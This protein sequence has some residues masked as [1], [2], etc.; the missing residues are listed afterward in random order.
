MKKK[1]SKILGIGL[2]LSLLLS[3]L[4]TAAPVSANVSSA[5]I[6][7]TSTVISAPSTYTLTFS[8]NDALAV[9]DTITV[10][11]P[12]GYDVSGLTVAEFQIA[13]TSGIGTTAF[14]LA[15]ASVVAVS[16]QSVTAT[17]TAGNPIGAGATVQVVIGD[18]TVGQVTNAG[19]LGDYTLEVNTSQ[20][21]TQVDSAAVTLTAPTISALP[22]I[23]EGKNSDGVTLFKATGNTAIDDAISTAGVAE[24]VVGPGTYTGVILADIA[25]QGITSSD[26]AATTIIDAVV[27][28]TNDAT[29]DGFTFE[30]AVTANSANEPTIE[31]SVVE[32]GVVVTQAITLDT[33][34]FEVAAAAIGVDVNGAGATITNSIFN[35]EGT[36]VDIGANVEVEDST[37]NGDDGDSGIGI[38]VSATSTAT[39]EGNTFDGLDHAIMVTG[40]T[41]TVTIE[42]NVISN[43]DDE[44]ITIGGTDPIVAIFGNT[45]SDNTDDFLEI[46]ATADGALVQ[47]NFN[48]IAGNTKSVDNNDTNGVDVTNNW[49]GVAT[50]PAVAS[51]GTVDTSPYLSVVASNP[52]I[53]LASATLT[54]EDGAG[55]DV[56]DAAGAAT[57][58]AAATYA[59]N[60]GTDDVP[61]VASAYYDVYV[62]G[63]AGGPITVMLYGDVS[64]DTEAYVWGAGLGEWVEASS[65]AVNVFAGSIAVTVTAATTPTI[66]D[67]AGLPFAI[68]DPTPS[69]ATLAAPVLEAPVVGDDDVSLSPTLAWAPVPGADGYELELANNEA[70]VPTLLADR[71]GKNAK[72][73]V[74]AYAH[75]GDL[76]YDTSYYWRVRAISGDWIPKIKKGYEIGGNFTVESDWSSS[77]FTTMSEPEEPTPPVIVTDKIMPTPVI[78]QPDITIKQPD[79]TITQPP[80]EIVVPLPPTAAPITPSW[81]YVIIGI[82]AV[83]VIAMIVLIVRTRRVA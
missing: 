20:E 76:P 67:L 66:A 36:G 3:L 38:A 45:I 23:V 37:F 78:E 16:S 60:P 8:I 32:A 52:A 33:V 64:A 80:L 61:G 26:G 44:A 34:T 65:Q 50:G 4:L 5:G 25:D 58:I 15:N 12:S 81:I 2:T 31:N 46:G 75:K 53:S 71:T 21:T 11:F 48:T 1:F 43:S 47:A 27:T 14:G 42:G 54:D 10:E 68:S 22:G 19:A 6:S 24:I 13:A 35:V 59:D 74:T 82:G 70:F 17:L 63:S 77:V 18:S 49:W 56:T 69:T 30:A 57:A 51:E 55:V 39:I 62:A 9:T 73:I 79:I 28:I 41:P 72:L 83:L 29:F 40:G 7:A